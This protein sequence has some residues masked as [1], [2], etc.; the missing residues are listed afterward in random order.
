TQAGYLF[1]HRSGRAWLAARR[2]APRARSETPLPVEEFKDLG[3]LLNA[4]RRHAPAAPR[5]IGFG[6]QVLR[7]EDV[8]CLRSLFPQAEAVDLS[9]VLRRLRRQKS[10]RECEYIRL[11]A[12]QADGA[13]KT[14]ASLLRLG[15]TE[16]EL[17]IRIEAYLRR[18]GHPGVVRFREGTVTAMG[19]IV[20]GA[21]VFAPERLAFWAGPG[22]SPAVPWGSGDRPFAL[23]EPVFLQF[24]G[25][26]A[27][28]LALVTRN[29]SLGPPTAEAG[30]AYEAMG[31]V[32]R[33]VERR[34]GPGERVEKLFAL[35]TR[36][37]DFLGYEGYFLGIGGGP[38]WP[39]GHGLGMEADELPL[40]FP[41]EKDVLQPGMVVAIVPK[42]FLPGLGL[43]G[44]GNTYLI[45][46]DGHE[47][48]TDVPEE[49]RMVPP[50]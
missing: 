17:S 24:F 41:G 47:K 50:D 16:L 6:F 30:W 7:Y 44:V 2:G 40:F 33:E 1:L 4:I 27:G 38:L 45:T 37:A 28:Y 39:L 13:V 29:L 18:K 22:L 48:L 21:E 49:W 31:R 10:L 20:G 25:S 32:L 43:I 15:Q 36:T 19:F 23:H 26:S 12:R 9:L 35:A 8:L 42:V 34:L 3:G 14:A 46:P 11:A 5:R